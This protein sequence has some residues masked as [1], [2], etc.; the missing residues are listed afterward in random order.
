[1]GRRSLKQTETEVGFHSRPPRYQSNFAFLT[2]QYGATES[3]TNMPKSC[4]QKTKKTETQ[5]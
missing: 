1:M 5:I 3:K 4:S 2:T